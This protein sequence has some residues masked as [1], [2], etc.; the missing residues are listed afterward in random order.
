M[1]YP[2]QILTRRSPIPCDVIV[3][4][5]GC[6]QCFV[7]SGEQVRAMDV[8][9]RSRMRMNCASHSIQSLCATAHDFASG[10][11]RAIE[12][13]KIVQS[14]VDSTWVLS[15]YLISRKSV[16]TNHGML[17]QIWIRNTVRESIVTKLLCRSH[18]ASPDFSV[19]FIAQINI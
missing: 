17:F 5:T 13:M 1:H 15:I 6:L 3:A 2:R 11:I 9:K 16:P 4:F 14:A 18:F 10:S 7:H 19:P 8:K 12:P